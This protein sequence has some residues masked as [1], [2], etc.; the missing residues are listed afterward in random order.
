MR[1]TINYKIKRNVVYV[2]SLQHMF[3]QPQTNKQTRQKL[4]AISTGI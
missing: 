3:T 4:C 2:A 1:K